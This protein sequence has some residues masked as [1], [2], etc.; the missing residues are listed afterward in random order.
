MIKLAIAKDI[1]S[2]KTAQKAKT[3]PYH[4]LSEILTLNLTIVGK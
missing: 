4:L 1:E 2:E 3:E